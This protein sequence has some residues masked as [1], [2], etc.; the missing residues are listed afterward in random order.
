[1]KKGDVLKFAKIKSILEGQ[2][3]EQLRVAS[4]VANNDG[5]GRSKSPQ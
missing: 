2:N 4:E 5:G 3:A 1:V